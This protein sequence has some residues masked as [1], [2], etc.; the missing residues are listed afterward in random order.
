MGYLVCYICVPLSKIAGAALVFFMMYCLASSTLIPCLVNSECIGKPVWSSFPLKQVIQKRLI[1]LWQY[2]RIS[3]S[4]IGEFPSNFAYANMFSFRHLVMITIKWVLG[5]R[6]TLQ[7][8]AY[9]HN[10]SNLSLHNVWHILY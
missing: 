6:C 5:R 8:I 7:C 2:F 9:V 10:T 3:L 1:D 4:Q